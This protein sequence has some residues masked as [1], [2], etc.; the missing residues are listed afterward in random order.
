[1]IVDERQQHR[2][3]GGD[4]GQHR[5]VQPIPGPQ[6]VAHRRLEATIDLPRRA[7]VRTDVQPFTREVRLQRPQARSGPAGGEHD[8]ADLRR[9]PLRP[10]ALEPERKLEQLG[11]CA[12]RDN[13][14]PGNERFEPAPA[15]IANPPVQRPARDPH[16]PTIG[17]QVLTLGERA[18][19]SAALR[20]R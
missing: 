8:L 1:M 19:Q 2:S 15:V 10:L 12:R 13:P 17:T 16:Q 5:A 6:L 9:G 20:F 3:P 18:G 14:R 11:R 4:P 7:A